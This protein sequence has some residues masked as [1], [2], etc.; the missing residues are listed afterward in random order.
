LPEA[1]EDKLIGASVSGKF[2]AAPTPESSTAAQYAFRQAS[3]LF[4]Q[5]Q[6]PAAEQYLR[7][8]LRLQ[9]DHFDALHLLGLIMRRQGRAGLATE[10]LRRA[11]SINRTSAVAHRHLANV[12][13]DA[14]SL[15]EAIAS[16]D[17]AIDLHPDFV[18]AHLGRGFTLLNLQRPRPALTSFDHVIRLRPND[19]VAQ[20]A[21]ATVLLALGRAE[22]ALECCQYADQ[23]APGLAETHVAWGAALLSLG[24]AAEALT[25][26]TL[27]IALQPSEAA[28]NGRGAALQDLQRPTEAL[29]SFDAAIALNS[30]FPD[31]YVNRGIACADLQNPESALANFNVAI[32]L[33]PQDPRAY[34]NMA[35][36]H[37][38]HGN[39]A[40]GWPLYEWRR[41]F[42]LDSAVDQSGRPQWAGENVRGKT[43]FIHS[44]QG[45]G[46]TLQ[47]CRYVKLVEALGA[48]VV[49]SV[50]DCLRR[51]LQ[52]LGAT[53][54][55]LPEGQMP[56][57]F[58]YHCPL[59][60]LPRA[61]G[62]T[63][64][65]MPAIVAYLH[66][67][68]DRVKHW[69]GVLPG[70]LRIGICWQGGLSRVDIG[71]SFPV[72][73]FE[74]IASIPG[75]RLISL[76][77]G[78]GAEQLNDL[79]SRMCVEQLGDQFDQGP[80]AFLDAAAVMESLDLV[81]TSDTAIAHLAGALNRPA[82]VVLKRVPDWRWLL[83][84]DD[85]PW[86]P[87]LRLFRQ[88]ESGV[89]AG[90]FDEMREQLINL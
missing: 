64:E 38:Q 41:R 50:Q 67:E 6:L 44:E 84:R 35:H 45:L 28:H 83:G 89:W 54:G 2:V 85:T 30:Q 26:F 1:A 16:F 60:S 77:K 32:R 43:V 61:F 40:Q 8:V 78:P 17:R 11:V 62:T 22:E 70:G 13:V 74:R 48:T 56:R 14:G 37:L 51:L 21:R 71:R 27:A 29:V 58:H 42:D 19:A 24:R 66:A 87:S 20:R 5:G 15:E 68:P 3:T 82:W 88:K 12:L 75:V 76:Q 49:L 36:L 52:G 53:V 69:R 73:L 90:V 4:R 72:A 23:L 10:L 65:S 81:I 7:H 33:R 34:L 31:A 25:S 18:E 46:D 86:Y 63:L 47:F 55:F 59:L 79:P 9:P 57:D 80:D 39:F